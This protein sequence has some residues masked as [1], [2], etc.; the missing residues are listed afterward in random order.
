MQKIRSGLNYRSRAIIRTLRLFQMLAKAAAPA[1]LEVLGQSSKPDTA[2][3]V[4]PMVPL[5]SQSVHLEK[6][7]FAFHVDPCGKTVCLGVVD[8]NELHR[9][10]SVG[11]G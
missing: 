9:M 3:R 6:A 2:R 7:N 5:G 4:I 10:N 11:H 1:E 8:D